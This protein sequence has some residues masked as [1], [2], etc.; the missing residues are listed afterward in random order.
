MRL[1]SG[2]N[3]TT[4]YTDHIYSISE[5]KGSMKEPNMFHIYE[6]EKKSLT[7]P[8]K[9]QNISNCSVFLPEIVMH[10][11]FNVIL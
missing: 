2:V 10:D 4:V 7:K 9:R 1:P 3:T 8:L 6:T 5:L 11:A